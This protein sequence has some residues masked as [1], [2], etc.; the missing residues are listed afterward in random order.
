VNESGSIKISNPAL[1][2]WEMKNSC[3]LDVADEGEH[4][5]EEV[6]AIANLVRE[7]IRQIEDKALAKLK[8]L[9]AVCELAEVYEEG[10]PEAFINS[11]LGVGS[12]REGGAGVRTVH[13]YSLW[14][15]ETL[16]VGR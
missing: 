6:G 13:G 11:G 9:S 14:G 5:L 1:E 15:T 7:R 12:S 3:A 8:A 4:T 2:V 10:S 16:G